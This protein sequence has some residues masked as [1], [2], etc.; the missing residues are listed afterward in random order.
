M[1]VRVRWGGFDGGR[2]KSG[3]SDMFYKL[4]EFPHWPSKWYLASFNQ[5]L[6]A[7]SKF[8]CFY[9]MFV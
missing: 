8:Q 1:T 4:P 2:P 5:N 9:I 6:T 7:L 3:N